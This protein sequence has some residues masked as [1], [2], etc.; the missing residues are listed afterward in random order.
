[1]CRVANDTERTF[2]GRLSPSD[3][4]CHSGWAP[5]PVTPLPYADLVSKNKVSTCPQCGEDEAVEI[6]YGLP[7]PELMASAARGHV[8][9]GG[10]EIAQGQPTHACKNC[11][12]EWVADGAKTPTA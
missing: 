9:L 7:G 4:L 1:M 6:V 2:A 5:I 11:D 8:V 10:C 3:F 12:H